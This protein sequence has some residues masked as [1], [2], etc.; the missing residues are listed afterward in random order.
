MPKLPLEKVIVEKRFRKDFGDMDGL[1]V[2]IQKYGL[3]HPICVTKDLRLIAGER[4]LKAHQMLGIKEIEVKFFEDLSDIDRKEI[5]LEENIVRKAFTWQEEVIAK[6]AIDQLKRKKYGSAIKGH[7]SDGWSQKN[8]AEALGQSVGTIS[9]DLQLAEALMLYPNLGREK[10][11]TGAYKKFKKLRKRDLRVELAKRGAF[12]AIPFI[13]LGDCT[14]VMKEKIDSDSVDMIAT[15]PQFG[16]Q[17]S[18]LSSIP[19]FDVVYKQD[20]TE[21]RVFNQLDLALAEMYR[22]LKEGS[23]LYIFFASMHYTLVRGLLEKRFV[24]DPIP[25]IWDK[26]HQTGP[27]SLLGY[28]N[29]YEPCFFCSKGPPKELYKWHKNVISQK[30]VPGDKR[31][32]PTEKPTGLWRV[33][34][35]ASSLPGDT[36]IDP[37]AGSGSLGEAALE[38]DRKTILIDIDE[39]YYDGMLERFSKYTKGDKNAG[40]TSS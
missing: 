16:V 11:K 26:E 28:T 13:Y 33:F 18:T 25:I 38:L 1:A 23:H 19:S 39:R 36:V 9:M 7:E 20:D 34:I 30:G 37:Y 27:G 22:I 24:V 14:K 5:E 32:H 35:E 17:L 8:T 31:I 21:Y 40:N 10:T 4:R 29:S 3:I 6:L 15:D 2:S 12:K